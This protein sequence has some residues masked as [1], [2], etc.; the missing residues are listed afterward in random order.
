M[1]T[2]NSPISSLDSL[3]AQLRDAVDRGDQA[4]AEELQRAIFQHLAAESTR[5]DDVE[6]TVHCLMSTFDGSATEPAPSYTVKSV[7][8]PTLSL[9][10]ELSAEAESS[11]YPVWFGTDRK[12]KLIGQ[13]FTGERN[14]S[15]TCGR[16]DVYIPK[17]HRPGE[18]GSSLLT[19]LF[20]LDLRDDSLR[21]QRIIGQTA[22]DFFGQLTQVMRETRAAGTEAHALFYL[23]GFNVGFESAAIRAAQLGKDLA[24]PGAT[25][26]FSWPSKDSMFQY[27][28]DEATIEASEPAIT[29]FLVDFAARCG[30]DKIHVIA[31]SMGNRGLLRALQRIATNAELRSKVRFGQILLAAPDVD[32]DVFADLAAMCQQQSDQTTLYASH[33]DLAVHASYWKHAAPRAGYFLPYTLVGGIETVAVPDLDIDRLGHSYYAQAKTLLEDMRERILPTGK[34]REQRGLSALMFEGKRL[35]SL[36]ATD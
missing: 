18:I 11:V 5:L 19:R 17:T 28:A 31:H 27:T 10:G 25:A 3:L 9:D 6:R 15:V 34:S 23:H 22:D 4:R 33:Q 1:T 8:A 14:R 26:F 13:G 20:R 21:I 24:I 32:Q 16:A 30:A 12:P 7:L 2:P 29:A 36:R 35:W